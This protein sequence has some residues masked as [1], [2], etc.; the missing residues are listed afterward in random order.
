MERN[1]D[2]SIIIACE[3]RKLRAEANDKDPP[4]ESGNHKIS[5][6]CRGIC[7]RLDDESAGGCR[8]FMHCD[9]WKYPWN[10]LYD[11]PCKFFKNPFAGTEE[12]TFY[13]IYGE[14]CFT[15]YRTCPGS[16]DF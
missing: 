11:E 8:S 5:E 10:T 16:M 3:W 6:R 12:T 4:I 13:G 9:Q 1:V 14:D 2:I 15:N 7:D